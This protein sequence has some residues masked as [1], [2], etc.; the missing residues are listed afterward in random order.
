M[1]GRLRVAATPQLERW[2]L[3]L[4][5]LLLWLLCGTEGEWC[6]GGIAGRLSYSG[7]VVGRC[8][9]REWRAGTGCRCY[10]CRR[11]KDRR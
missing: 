10:C 7:I 4:L 5:L 3:L 9:E 6:R 8:T 11:T 2:L 1:I